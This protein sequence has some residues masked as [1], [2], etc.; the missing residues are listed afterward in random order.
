[1]WLLIMPQMYTV[2]ETLQEKN[3]VALFPIRVYAC[4]YI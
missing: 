2:T 3:Y 4:I 1:M